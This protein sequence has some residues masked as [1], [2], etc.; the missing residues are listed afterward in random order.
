MPRRVWREKLA[1]PVAKIVPIGTITG[2]WASEQARP[3]WK[4]LRTIYVSK[5][6]PKASYVP[7]GRQLQGLIA[8]CGMSL[9]ALAVAAGIP[10]P[11]LHRFL[12]GVRANIRLDTADKLCRYFDV[13]LTA[14]RR[15][16]PRKER[17]A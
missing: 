4:P 17:K 9:N 5:N 6:K 11:V 3:G 10:E 15:P 16:K 13:R 7:L 12:S 2:G 8:D 1:V 14:P